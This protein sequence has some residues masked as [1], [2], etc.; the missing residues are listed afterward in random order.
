V[1]A[2]LVNWD[3]TRDQAIGLMAR[4]SDTGLGTTDGYALTYQ[5]PDHDIDITRIVNEGGPSV[6]LS[7]TSGGVTFVPGK[8]YRFVFIGKGTQLIGRIYELP[9]TDTPIIEVS[10]N[11]TLPD[12]PDSLHTSGKSGLIV[13]DN[14]GGLQ[15]T[16]AT[17]DN[18]YA[19]DIEPPRLA[20]VDYS[21]GDYAV[22][23]P[24]GNQFILQGASTLAPNG[25]EDLT[26]TSTTAGTHFYDFTPGAIPGQ[27]FF[28]L[29]RR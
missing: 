26:P 1:A 20:L 17:F 29:I 23:W 5:V 13:F 10:G 9:N 11:D 19:S 14:S 8:S 15:V 18:Y 6:P 2:D 4:V 24:E 12:A 16:D 22:S 28:R 3:D 21:F 25:W 7:P 27:R